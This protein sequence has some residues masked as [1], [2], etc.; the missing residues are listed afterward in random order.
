[1]AIPQSKPWRHSCTF[2]R[3]PLF[4]CH[5]WDSPDAIPPKMPRIVRYI[6]VDETCRDRLVCHEG[7]PEDRVLVHFNPVDL[8]RFLPRG[9]LP[10]R[11]QRALVFSNYARETNYLPAV[12][13]ACKRAGIQLDVAGEGSQRLSQHPEFLLSAYDIVFAKA[14]C[15]LE[16]LA[17]GT[18]VILCDETGMGPMVTLSDFRALRRMNFGRRTLR[19]ALEPDRI[20]T[21]IQPNFRDAVQVSQCIRESEGL[22]SS[23]ESLEKIYIDAVTDFR[24]QGQRGE[25]DSELRYVAA[26]L[27]QIAPFSNTFYGAEQVR[28]AERH[29][30]E[31]AISEL[32]EVMPMHPLPMEDRPQIRIVNSICPKSSANCRKFP[33][34]P[35]DRTDRAAF[36]R[37]THR[38]RFTF[39]FTGS[40]QTRSKPL[41]SKETGQRS[42]RRC[43]RDTL[44]RIPLT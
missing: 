29:T 12:R 32:A 44:T 7:I 28:A 10:E 4:T 13:E 39:R 16:A 2:R 43:R 25:C 40:R 17:V 23:A 6:A 33:G 18:A 19:M 36:S 31:A 3:A 15:A 20:V 5:G 37:V 27:Q 1:M 8:K 42:I 14:R 21:E 24:N 34:R 26:F 30:R 41:C 9:P 22:E 35:G 11:P 38:I